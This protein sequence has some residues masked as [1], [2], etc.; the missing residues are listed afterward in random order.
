MAEGL[1]IKLAF[2]C[3]VED[4]VPVCLVQDSDDTASVVHTLMICY[5]G[6]TDQDRGVEASSIVTWYRGDLVAKLCKTYYVSPRSRDFW[7]CHQHR[8]G[9]CRIFNRL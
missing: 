4:S 2:P 3:G 9:W 5:F 8:R 6:H 1:N 7:S